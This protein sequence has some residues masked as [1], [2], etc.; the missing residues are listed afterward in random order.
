[1]NRNEGVHRIATAIRSIAILIVA[2]GIIDTGIGYEPYAIC[3]VCGGTGLGRADSE[4]LDAD[5]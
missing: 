3:D 5:A 4:A 2:L 1:M